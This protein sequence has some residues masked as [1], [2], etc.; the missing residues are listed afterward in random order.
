MA[1]LPRLPPRAEHRLLRAVCGLPPRVLRM[2]FGPPK[3]LDG[4]VL[5][6]DI[7]ALIKLSEWAG[8]TSITEQATPAEARQATRVA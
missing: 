4:Q 3:E 8:E 7:Q 1:D 5:A 6:S 2:L